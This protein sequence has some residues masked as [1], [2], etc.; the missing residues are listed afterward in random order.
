M[1]KILTNGWTCRMW[2]AHESGCASSAGRGIVVLRVVENRCGGMLGGRVQYVVRRFVKA[3]RY[4]RGESWWC[5]LLY[6]ASITRNI[7]VDET[8]WWALGYRL[9]SLE[10]RWR[11][12]GGV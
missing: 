4:N 11:F 10:V 9:K 6:M 2:D 5:V 7:S 3:S 12:D 1:G 8:C